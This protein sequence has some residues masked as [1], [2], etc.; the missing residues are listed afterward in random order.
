MSMYDIYR[1]DTLDESD[2]WIILPPMAFDD[3]ISMA[4]T[5][6]KRELEFEGTR[7]LL[8]EPECQHPFL[9]CAIIL[10]LHEGGTPT[11]ATYHL[12]EASLSYQELVQ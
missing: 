4:R 10:H 2:G 3:A 6:A 7:R 9:A 8:S 1:F 12:K 5:L 11:I